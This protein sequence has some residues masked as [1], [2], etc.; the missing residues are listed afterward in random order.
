MG[1][2]GILPAKAGSSDAVTCFF[3]AREGSA[4]KESVNT[5]DS[6]L[7]HISKLKMYLTLWL[8]FM[9]CD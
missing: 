3:T 9:T 8:L 1:S 7:E 4:M 2:E 5:L 6:L